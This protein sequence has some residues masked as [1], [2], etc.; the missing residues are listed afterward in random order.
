MLW[1]HLFILQVGLDWTLLRDSRR[2]DIV[3]N[4]LNSIQPNLRTDDSGI[5]KNPME[6]CI[7]LNCAGAYLPAIEVASCAVV[8]R[9]NNGGFIRTFSIRLGHCSILEAELWTVLYDLWERNSIVDGGKGFFWCYQAPRWQE[10]RW[11]LF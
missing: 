4:V 3:Q 2:S 10:W 9:G 5:W 7:K 8:L 1:H 6:G 11:K